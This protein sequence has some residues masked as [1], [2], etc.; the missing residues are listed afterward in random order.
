MQ[1]SHNRAERSA[2]IFYYSPM[3]VPSLPTTKAVADAVVHY[4]QIRQLSL[5]E[6][7]YVIALFDFDLSVD[8][9]I[10][11]ERAQRPA[12]VDELMAIAFALDVSPSLLLTHIPIQQ[13]IEGQLATGTVDNLDPFELRDW[14]QGK[15]HLDRPSRI[16]WHEEK[17]RAL[18]IKA[19]HIDEQFAGACLE[20]QELGELA[21]RESEA[22]HVQVLHQRIDA[23][24]RELVYMDCAIACAQQ[25]LDEVCEEPQWD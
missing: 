3:T 13:P 23:G 18:Q 17:V 1:L 15:T 12:T 25:H 7:S 14:V 8:D 9:L 6:L 11:I 4:R 19:A 5:D 21:E 2:R 16:A 22:M 24:K 20:L 10:D